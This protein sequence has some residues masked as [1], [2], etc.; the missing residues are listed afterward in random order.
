M[1]FHYN[2][3]CVADKITMFSAKSGRH[4][5]QDGAGP[6]GGG[7][8]GPWASQGAVAIYRGFSLWLFNI[9]MENNAF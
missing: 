8:R 4:W 7:R 5:H 3:Q 1:Y 2:P 9:A 6:S